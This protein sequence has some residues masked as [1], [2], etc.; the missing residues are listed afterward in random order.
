MAR[1]LAVEALHADEE[2]EE[3]GR[4]AR[5]AQDG[6]PDG[7][8]P[9]E[10]G[11]EEAS[12][13][14]EK[15]AR[16]SF[17]HLFGDP[18]GGD[19]PPG[20]S[21]TRPPPPP[22]PPPRRRTYTLNPP[23]PSSPPPPRPRQQEGK[24]SARSSVRSRRPPARFD[25]EL[26]R[27]AKGHTDSV[28]P[29]PPQ[30][31]ESED[32]ERSSS[33]GGRVAKR[34]AIVVKRASEFGPLP[35]FQEKERVKQE[36]RSERAGT[37]FRYDRRASTQFMW[38]GAPR[39]HEAAEQSAGQSGAEAGAGPGTGTGV[40]S[41][42]ASDSRKLSVAPGGTNPSAA[43]SRGGQQAPAGSPSRPGS[44]P[45]GRPSPAGASSWGTARPAWET[46]VPAWK[47][48]GAGA[49]GGRPNQTM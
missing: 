2:D 31:R 37:G 14:E 9:A 1:E 17:P 4:D 12:R 42:S 38:G 28:I 34:G 47:R 32:D 18:A 23:P 11:A 41:A 16:E 25:P 33:E 7:P 21:P 44:A 13:H 24:G 30:P 48:A 20:V 27:A 26:V 49:R 6:S 39:R 35:D 46:A 22:T 45:R 8:D 19:A 36:E 10:T 29:L 43:S 15:R 5:R 40:A 3:S